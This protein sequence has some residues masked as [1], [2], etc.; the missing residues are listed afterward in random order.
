M[1]AVNGAQ[2]FALGDQVAAVFGGGASYMGGSFVPP[3]FVI[4]GDSYSTVAG[5]FDAVNGQ[6]TNLYDSI[7]DIQTTPGPQG[8]EG[9]AGPQGPAGPEGPAGPQGPEG[10][11]GP[12]GPG[13]GD[14]NA[15]AYDDEAGSTLTL[16][17]ESGTRV[18]NVADGVDATD[19]VN[20]GQMDAG[21]TATLASAH[22]YTD[23]VATRTLT[24][25][26]TYTDQQ[27]TL[28]NDRFEQ[29][30]SEQDRRIDKLGAMSGALTGMAMNSANLRG[31]NRMAVG[32]G[33]QGGSQAF[34]VGYQRALG[35]AA[36]ISIG[37]AFS[38][39]EST[40]SAGAGFS[41]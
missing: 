13:G 1:Q 6:I 24:Q 20:K 16:K 29:R 32:V 23:T 41:W 17:G 35:E 2:L 40:L 22:T 12:A 14:P 15:V 34:A 27:V 5:A 31:Q 3:T 26:N 4:Q 28:L 19:A 18:A 25:A 21:D 10:P 37:A 11:Q 39:S 33:A 9:P 30:F 38:G 8:P 7:A 36:S